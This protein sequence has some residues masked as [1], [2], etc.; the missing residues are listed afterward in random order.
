ML[1]PHFKDET[2]IARKNLKQFRRA[3]MGPSIGWWTL[4]T[5][6]YDNDQCY[7][8]KIDSYLFAAATMISSAFLGY[9]I[10]GGIYAIGDYL[11]FHE[12]HATIVSISVAVVMV[13]T[14]I[15]ALIW[16]L[17]RGKKS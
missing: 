13:T 11:K 17:T 6:R 2:H 12:K 10:V 3:M 16:I 8:L 5:N 4:F 9:C 1:I 14:S 7:R 15:A